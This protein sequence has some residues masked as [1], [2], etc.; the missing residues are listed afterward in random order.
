MMFPATV[1]QAKVIFH[2]LGAVLP[3]AESQEK[4]RRGPGGTLM[5]LPALP[6][7]PALFTTVFSFSAK[8]ELDST[9]ENEMWELT[10]SLAFK[11][12]SVGLGSQVQPMPGTGARCNTEK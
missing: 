8:P 11:M 4:Q 10:G 12:L 7:S 5:S 2:E 9:T 1:V 3:W 6:G